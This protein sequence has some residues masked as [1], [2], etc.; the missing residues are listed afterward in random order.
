MSRNTTSLWKVSCYTDACR[1]RTW[2]LWLT[3]SHTRMCWFTFR[4]GA[5]L[6]ELREWGRDTDCTVSCWSDPSELRVWMRSRNNP[7]GQGC[8]YSGNSEPKK[9]TLQ[10]IMV[11][12]DQQVPSGNQQNCWAL[13]TQ[14]IRSRKRTSRSFPCAGQKDN[15]QPVRLAVCPCGSVTRRHS[16]R[17]RSGAAPLNHH[18][19]K[20]FSYPL[21]GK[22]EIS[23]RGPTIT[24]LKSSQQQKYNMN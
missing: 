24:F 19:P 21:Q 17:E 12:L 6:W 18:L 3:F 8:P 20:T 1:S 23:H 14:P 4:A 16:S 7:C 10:V 11:S 2:N 13:Q 9:A 22:E 5:T 15:Q